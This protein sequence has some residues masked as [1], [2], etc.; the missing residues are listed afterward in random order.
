MATLTDEEKVKALLGEVEGENPDDPAEEH[1]PTEN[2]EVPEAAEV[3]SEEEKPVEEETETDSSFTK[4]SQEFK[5]QFPNLKGE[6]P[7]E[8]LP[9]L[10][11]AYDNSFKESLRLVEENKQ[12]KARLSQQPVQTDAANPQPPVNPVVAAIDEHPDIV[13]ARSKR[14]ADML[15]AFDDFKQKYP[16]ATEQQAFEQLTKASD[17]INV[18]LTNALGRAPTYRELFPAIAGSL[19]WQP[20]VDTAKKNAVIKE[21]AASSRSPG[22]QSAAAKRPSKVT[23]AQVDMYLKLSPS[24]T[25]E[26]AIKELSEVV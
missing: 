25:R 13:Y 3:E 21:N 2:E 26:E 22:S 18:A 6:T 19:G 16:Q 15:A 12:L 9:E 4:N 1:D 11:K 10:E 7:A 14:T 17:G 20:A 5:K 23:D 24:K 8:Y